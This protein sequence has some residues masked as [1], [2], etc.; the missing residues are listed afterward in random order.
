MQV[1][2]S[3]VQ[4][5]SRH[6]TT[7]T[8]RQ[9][10]SVETWGL[11]RPAPA[12]TVSVSAEAAK[13]AEARATEEDEEPVIDDK[14][15]ILK[16]M[17]E[18]L[19]GEDIEV[20]DPRDWEATP[21]QQKAFGDVVEAAR[22]ADGW[23]MRIDVVEEVETTERTGF[24][25]KARIQTEDGRVFD[26]DLKTLQERFR[27]VRRE[28]HMQI[29]E[30]PKDPL[31]LDFGAP[32][33]RSTGSSAIDLDRDGKLDS[34]AHL[35]AASAWLVLD[36]NG[37][38]AA[39]DGSELFGPTSGDAFAE[40]QALDRDGNGFVDAGDP[41]WSR[42]RLWVQDESGGRLVALAD[43][44]V[45]ALFVGSV[46]APFRILDGGDQEVGRQRAMSFWVGEDGHAGTTRRV[47]VL[48]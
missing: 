2:A 26:I 46:A 31:A 33:T 24:R 35:G 43:R 13:A 45:G 15:L 19:T 7:T 10:V 48:G 34:L 11:D 9:T 12:D 30:R 6:Q 22:A 5:S 8:H 36:R 44:G 21:E 23:G 39:D 1:T 27:R 47:D 16:M 18:E 3:A 37:N 29:G 40:L 38:G 42:L 4:L 41:A 32:S 28:A 25:A 14:L 20:F 17:L